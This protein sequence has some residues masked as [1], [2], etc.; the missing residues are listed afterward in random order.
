MQP[1]TSED[2]EADYVPSPVKGR[3]RQAKLSHKTLGISSTPAGAG[4]GKS[5]AT[6]VVAPMSLLA[7]WRDEIERCSG[8]N[9][10]VHM[11]YGAGKT[12]LEEE[13]EDG[14]DVILTR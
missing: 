2:D 8:K 1:S 6:L 7:Q 13:L 14:V 3:R 4:G 11:Y 9:M 10:R 12:D 5:N